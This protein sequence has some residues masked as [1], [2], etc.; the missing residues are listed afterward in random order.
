MN[1]N[2]LPFVITGAIL[3]LIAAAFIFF[4]G[5]YIDWLW[6]ESVGFT[7]VW[8]T[9]LFTKIQLFLIVGLLTAAIIASNVYIAFKRR[10]LYVPTSV[11]ISGVERLRA[12]IEPIRRW[13][14]IGITAALIYF[15]GSSGMVF[16]K[17]WVLFSNLE[18]ISL[19]S[20]LSCRCIKR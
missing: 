8:S 4:S 5:Y 7:S 2:R 12:Q 18:S 3:F 9:V 13:V 14:F 6:F 17:E 11:E 10:P 1:R 15:A 20:P 16:W 19:S